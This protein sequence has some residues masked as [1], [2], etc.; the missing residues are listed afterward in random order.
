[1]VWLTG[2]Y[3]CKQQLAHI[4]PPPSAHLTTALHAVPTSTESASEDGSQ[5]KDAQQDR[6]RSHCNFKSAE[7]AW[8]SLPRQ[9]LP[10]LSPMHVL[11]SVLAVSG[12][13]Y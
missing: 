2:M 13:L 3:S 4:V 11:S 1:M 5:T 9:D 7:S 6:H 10:I 8:V 12:E